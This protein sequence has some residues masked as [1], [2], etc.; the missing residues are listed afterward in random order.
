MDDSVNTKAITLPGNASRNAVTLSVCN[1]LF[2]CSISIDLSLTGITGF[3]LA[4]T[5]SLAT[6]PFALITLAGAVTTYFAA[7]IIQRMGSKFGFIFGALVG[8][9]GGLVSVISVLNQ[10]FW[11][12]CAGTAAVGVWQAFAQYYRLAAADAV[13]S[14]Y[15]AKAISGV[16]AGGLIAAILGPLLATSSKDFFDDGFFAGA[17]LVVAALSLLTIFILLLFYRDMPL[18]SSVGSTKNAPTVLRSRRA[19]LKQP[20]FLAAAANNAVGGMVMMLIMTA[21][22]LAAMTCGYS[23]DQGASVIQWHLVGMYAP[24]FFAGKLINKYGLSKILYCGM[25]LNLISVTIA[26][27]SVSLT[28]FHTALFILGV[29]WNFMFVGGSILLAQ[30]Y[31]EGEQAKAQGM[32]EFLRFAATAIGA[33][34]AGPTLEGLGWSSLNL[35]ALPFI[36]LAFGLTIWWRRAQP[37]V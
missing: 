34:V 21:A 22:P 2:I 23:V 26:A 25:A 35:V 1:A 4:P 37:T 15:K 20:V 8:A 9:V 11:M 6:L 19:I 32:G 10:N 27:N 3:Q 7:G 33:L 24:S 14:E 5:P 30:S 18:T 28:G 36:G 12:F 31:R 17:Y 13:S 16:L 29:G